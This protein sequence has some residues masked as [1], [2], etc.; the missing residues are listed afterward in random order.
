MWLQVPSEDQNKAIGNA[1]EQVLAGLLGRKP[2]RDELLG[3]VLLSEDM[4]KEVKAA[5]PAAD[6]QI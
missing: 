1:Y 3:N 4:I 6:Y 2:T 5:K